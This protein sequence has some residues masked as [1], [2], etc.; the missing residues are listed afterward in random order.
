MW[1]ELDVPVW[2]E[3][4]VPV[5]LELD[6]EVPVPVGV[7]NVAPFS[8][9]EQTRCLVKSAPVP[10][11]KPSHARHGWAAQPTTVARSRVDEN[12]CDTRVTASVTMTCSTDPDVC[13][14]ANDTC[15]ITIT[16]NGTTG[17]I[18]RSQFYG[19]LRALPKRTT[20]ECPDA[21]SDVD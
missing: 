5:W 6:V 8:T 2:L 12:A 19:F 10:A 4:D 1:L 18:V 13:E 20:K 3:L 14:N 9:T 21:S 7:G 17:Q 15:E 16:I 11:V